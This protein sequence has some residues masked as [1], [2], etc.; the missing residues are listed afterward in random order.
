MCNECSLTHITEQMDLVSIA[1]ASPSS[2]DNMTF[3]GGV[4]KDTDLLALLVVVITYVN[5]VRLVDLQHGH[6]VI[7]S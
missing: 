7:S 1:T 4:A 5:G 2:S 6:H 3:A